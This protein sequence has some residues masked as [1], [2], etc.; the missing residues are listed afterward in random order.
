MSD[1]DLLAELL[2]ELFDEDDLRKFV[3]GYRSGRTILR[4]LAEEDDL[5][6]VEDI[7]YFVV[8]QW[9][10]RNL[11]D[12]ELQDRLVNA[13]PD[14]ESSIAEVFDELLED[15]FDDFELDEEDDDEDDDDDDLDEFDVDEDDGFEDDFEDEERDPEDEDAEADEEPDEFD[16]EF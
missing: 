4:L 11:I 15:D 13:H 9:D 16:E 6:D 10:D 14:Y 1:A 12:N 2:S 3:R 8:Q 7:A 5:G